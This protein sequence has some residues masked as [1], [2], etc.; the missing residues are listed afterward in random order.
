ARGVKHGWLEAADYLPGIQ[1]AWKG[2]LTHSIDREGNIYGVCM[3]SGC[4]M[5]S[6]YYDTI[7]TVKNDDHGTGVILAAAGE[8]YEMLERIGEGK[9]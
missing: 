9:L 8:L 6:E 5:D 1:K 3:G 4:S 2:L 7:P